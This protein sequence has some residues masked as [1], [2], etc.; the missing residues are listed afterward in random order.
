M[1]RA[2]YTSRNFD[3][4]A[5]ATSRKQAVDTLIEGLNRHGKQYDCDPDWWYPEDICVYEFKSGAV[6]RDGISI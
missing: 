1:W 2:E 5:Y 4:E 6:Y 3:F